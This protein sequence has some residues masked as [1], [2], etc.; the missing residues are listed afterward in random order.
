MAEDWS[1]LATKAPAPTGGDWSDLGKPPPKPAAKAAPQPY[2]GPSVK[3]TPKDGP[4]QFVADAIGWTK[5]RASEAMSSSVARRKQEGV[6]SNPVQMAE[7]WIDIASVVLSPVG[8]TG[9]AVGTRINPTYGKPGSKGDEYRKYGD[10]AEMLTPVP[11]VGKGVKALV[12]GAKGVK[13]L[14][15][16]AKGVKALVTGAK[17]L[18]AGGRAAKIASE[19]ER[20]KPPGEPIPAKAKVSPAVQDWSDLGKPQQAPHPE[21]LQKALAADVEHEP[22]PE[23]HKPGVVGDEA[24]PVERVDNALYRNGNLA[25]E[26]KIDAQ[27]HMKAVPAEIKDAKVQEE[28]T[29]AIEQ[30][31]IDPNAE[32]P[33]HL[34]AAEEARQPWAERQRVAVNEV[35]DKLRAKGL[36]DEE[37]EDYL[38]DSGYVPRR[39]RG[40]SPG[41][42]PKDPDAKGRDP[43]GGGKG[44]LSKTTGSLRQRDQIVLETPEGERIFQHRD[45]NNKDWQVGDTQTDPV[46][47]KTGTI[48]QATIKEIEGAGARD[49]DGN[50][51]TYHKNALANTVDEA[52][53]AERVNRNIDVLDEITK[54]LEEQGLAHREE[55]H[56]QNEAGE[57]VRARANGKTPEGFE[58]LPNI[59]Q[60]KGWTF[61]KKIAE[62]LKDYYPGAHEPIDSVLSKVNRMLNA[63][64]FVTPIPHIKNV[65][66][67]AFIGRGM[68]M[69]LHPVRGFRTGLEA[70]HEVLTLG[71]KYKKFLREGAGL[72]AA[73]DATRNF[74][75]GLLESGGKTIESDPKTAA[76]IARAFGEAPAK[77]VKALYAASHKWLWI[78]NDTML[79]QRQLE[80]AEK[81][82]S[83]REAIKESERWIANYRVPSQVFKSRAFRQAL[84]NGK[85]IN[86]GRYTYGK[87]KPYGELYKNLK[88]TPAEKA[89]ALGKIAMMAL[90]T[91]AIYPAMDKIVQKVS[92]N[93]NAKVGMGGPLAPV[94]AVI[95]AAK[96]DKGYG[97]TISSFLTPAPMIEPGIE[98]LTNKV[99]FS[100]RDVVDPYASTKGKIVQAGEAA[101]DEFYPTQLAM[102]V[103]GPGGWQQAVG[104]LAGIN[105]PAKAPGQ[106]GMKASTKRRLE[107]QAKAREK[108]DPIENMIP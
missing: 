21:K 59:P 49:S 54:G 68:D 92:G 70:A 5:T 104:A 6:F 17:E 19:A 73:D 12:T 96:G 66:T 10:L 86:F 52:L 16:G 56:Y 48:K 51:L 50:L 26:G 74:Y 41:F 28:L 53:K 18:A 27:Q 8:G 78:A 38:P 94:G 57:W 32:I 71:P 15:T 25:T 105:L 31:M 82:M 87:W 45:P 33:E 65:A 37:I 24:D 100:G 13:A 80:L 30:R 106:S 101:A 60:L 63:S 88:G 11:P 81:G 46:A 36:T 99:P 93:P 76:E 91:T 97:G 108:K 84:T 4:Q 98:L 29:H 83:E 95:D 58:A 43:L 107:A 69:V 3:A 1:D 47:G 64:L 61:D 7:D 103:A 2:A 22:A 77:F 14:V 102:D 39:V 75:Q 42:D 9:D 20:M 89:D 79:L 90:L 44:G 62:V 23:I 35:R 40:K 72:M 34:K 67:A 85:L 55:W